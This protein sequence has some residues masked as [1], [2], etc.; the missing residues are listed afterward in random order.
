MARNATLTESPAG[1]DEGDVRVVNE[2]GD[3]P[4]EEIGLRSEVGVEDDD[5][6]AV[7]DVVMFQAFFECSSFVPASAFSDLVGD[8]D[9]FACPP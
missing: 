4:P 8:V 5:V 3:G 1:L 7:L 6:L 9:A 2:K